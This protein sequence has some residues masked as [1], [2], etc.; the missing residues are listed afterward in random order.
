M[1]LFRRAKKPLLIVMLSLAIATIFYFSQLYYASASNERV[2]KIYVQSLISLINQYQFLPDLLAENYLIQETLRSENFA[3]NRL[4]EKLKSIA[5]NTGADAVYLMN[6]A[7]TVVATSN[8][9]QAGTFLN[10]NYSFRPYFIKAVGDKTRQFYYAKG[11]TTGIP[12]FFISSPVVSDGQVQGVIVV[13]LEMEYWEEVWKNADQ[14]I[15]VADKNKIILLSTKEAWRYRSIGEI[16]DETLKQIESQKQFLGAQHESIYSKATNLGVWSTEN[17]NLWRIDDKLYLVNEVYIPRTQWVLYYLV[18]HN[19]IVK[20]AFLVF[21]IVLVFSLLLYFLVKGHY[22]L[23]ESNRNNQLIEIKRKK[24]FQAIVDNVGMGIV[25]LTQSKSIISANEYANNLL[26]DVAEDLGGKFSINDFVCI[27]DKEFNNLLD[28]E[29]NSL[30]YFET[31]T[32]YPKNNN[33][34]VMLFAKKIHLLDQDVYLL[35]VINISKRKQAENELLEVNQ[36]LE[37]I[38]DKKTKDL[39]LAQKE[40]IQKNKVAA[41]GNMAATIVHELSQPLTA[42][43]SSIAAVKLKVNGDDKEGAIQSANRL[44]PLSHKMLG[45][46]RMLKT[47]SYSRE[48]DLQVLPVQ[49]L[50]NKSVDSFKDVFSQHNIFL[51]VVDAKEDVDVKVNPIKLDLVFSNIIQ[52]AIDVVIKNGKPR[53]IVETVIGDEWVEVNIFDNGKGVGEVAIQKIF[54]PYFTTK[55][56]GKGLGLG[57]AISYEII[58][59]YGGD[60]IVSNF[61]DGACFSVKLPVFF[62]KMVVEANNT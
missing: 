43:N 10:K 1:R 19:V 13:K 46:I 54:S 27:D 61:Q 32:I 48:D 53:V 47:F 18:D 45:I 59:E 57:L 38:V 6:L 37:R 44:E 23:R 9:Q 15:L 52:N 33:V 3:D 58:Q 39:K 26:I 51:A 17:S 8:Y 11:A 41:L 62:N 7:G 35:T 14:T 25:I 2:S 42:M 60:I 16:S 34:P 40:L 31:K 29:D 56:I 24:E 20:L 22:S 49:A 28:Y 30:S 5:D 12:G 36:N 21:V 50:V 4:N 55:E